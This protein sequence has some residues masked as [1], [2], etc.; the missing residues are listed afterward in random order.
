[1]RKELRKGWRKPDYDFNRETRK[2]LPN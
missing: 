2:D 1:M